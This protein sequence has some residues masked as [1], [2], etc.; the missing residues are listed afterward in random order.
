[1]KKLILVALLALGVSEAKAADAS[2]EVAYSSFMTVGVRC[3]SGTANT[4]INATYPTGFRANV[5]GYRLGNQDSADDVFIGGPSL[6]TG[7][8]TTDTKTDLG[9]KIA[10]GASAPWP[11]GKTYLTG[12]VPLIPVYCK[13]E[14][15]AGAAGVTL[16]V[17]WFGY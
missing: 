16:S 14:D 11:V 15:D 9:E 3:S 7:T 12:G 2:F 1:M 17:V 8:V 13:A 4:Q 5:A 6:S 10:A